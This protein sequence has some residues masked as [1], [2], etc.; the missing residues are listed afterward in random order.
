MEREMQLK[1]NAGVITANG[2]KVGEID[3]VVIDPKTDEVT[4]IVIRKGF[5]F[6]EDKVVP[7]N[8]ISTAGESVVLNATKTMVDSLPHFEETQYIPRTDRR[9]P[10]EYAQPYYWYPSASVNWWGDA[11][12]RTLFGSNMSP[13]VK[14]TTRAT[15]EGTIPLKEGAKVFSS[16][17]QQVGSIER[18][19][20]DPDSQRAT[21]IVISAGLIFKEK[22]L[23]PTSWI[24]I[25]DEDEVFLG[26]SS[27]FLDMLVN[28]EG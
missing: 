21:H 27:K 16:D 19:F 20:A 2:D 8:W 3:R 9:Y 23:I 28:F 12:Y 25:M 1:A 7:V 14:V 6:T 5:L 10:E 11:G 24:D 15:P 26:V 13:Y 18:V 4:H 22:K 17:N